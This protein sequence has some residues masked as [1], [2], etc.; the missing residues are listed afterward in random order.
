MDKYEFIIKNNIF[1]LEEISRLRSISYMILYNLDNLEK[2]LRCT[3]DIPLKEESKSIIRECIY[4]NNYNLLKWRNRYIELLQLKKF[5]NIKK[6][7]LNQLDELFIDEFAEFIYSHSEK[8]IYLTDKYNLA[9]EV[10]EELIES[11]FQIIV[12]QNY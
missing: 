7:L 8:I 2:H 10:I 6:F 5:H 9:D 3:K 11:R 1:T 4:N 12:L